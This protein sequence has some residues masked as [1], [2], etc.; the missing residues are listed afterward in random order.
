MKRKC[1]CCAEMIYIDQKNSNKAICYKDK[2][3]HFDCFVTLCDQKMQSKRS[4]SMWVEAKENIENLVVETTKK[5]MEMVAKDDLNAWILN[6]YNVSFLGKTFYMKLSDIYNGSYKGLAYAIPPTELLDEWQ[7]FWNDLC[8]TRANKDIDGERAIN[9]DLVVLLSRN[10]EY[11]KIKY[12]ERIA[13]EVREQQRAQE[14]VVNINAIKGTKSQK[15]KVSDLYQEMN[16]G[17]NNE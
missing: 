9:Y 15:R 3:Y 16:G 5:Q 4:S 14:A 1:T 7:Y 6:H 10:A 12:K 8:A 17:E 11:R 2:F 13:R